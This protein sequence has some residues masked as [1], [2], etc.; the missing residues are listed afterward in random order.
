MIPIQDTV[1]GRNPPLAVYTLVGLNVLVFAF[2]LTLPHQELERLLYLLGIVPRLH[3]SA[4]GHVG[5][6]PGRRLLAVPDQHVPRD[7]RGDTDRA[8]GG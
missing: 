1:R 7:V 2:E 8:G 4:V 6:P 3:S 5:R